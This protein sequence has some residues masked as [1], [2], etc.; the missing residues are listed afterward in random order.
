M[1]ADEFGSVRARIIHNSARD[2][3]TVRPDDRDDV[4][5]IELVFDPS[6]SRVKQAC[7]P[8]RDRVER[9]GIDMD[10]AGHR[11]CE[12]DPTTLARQSIGLANKQ[13]SF[14]IARQYSTDNS[15]LSAVRD[16]CHAARIHGDMCGL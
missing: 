8:L 4:A 3:L 16:N 6:D 15:S 11:R 9:T 1:L 2:F 13:G 12:S 10:P 7:V 5:V 14:D